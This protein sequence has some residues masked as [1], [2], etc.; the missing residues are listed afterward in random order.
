[1]ETESDSKKQGEHGPQVRLVMKD[2]MTLGKLLEANCSTVDGFAVY[3][4]GWDDER[5]LGLFMGMLSEPRDYNRNHVIR[6]RRELFGNLPPAPKPVYRVRNIGDAWEMVE[7]GTVYLPTEGKTPIYI[8]PDMHKI[9]TS[10][11]DRLEVVEKALGMWKTETVREMKIDN[12]PK[13]L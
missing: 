4:D 7:S 1:M 10:L 3:A 9:L 2:A 5:V 6:V 12:E 13:L 11:F 8:K